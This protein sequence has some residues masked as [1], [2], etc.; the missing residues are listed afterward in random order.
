MKKLGFIPYFIFTIESYES[1]ISTHRFEN[2]VSVSTIISNLR[3]W[4]LPTP[5]NPISPSDIYAD[6][7]PEMAQVGQGL[8]IIFFVT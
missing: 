3:H 5:P 8:F 2:I 4:G 1:D 6:D 7:N